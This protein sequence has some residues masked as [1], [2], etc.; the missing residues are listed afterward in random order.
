[1]KALTALN[2]LRPSDSCR[3]RTEGN[4]LLGIRD[5]FATCV[6]A[7]QALR[8][9]AWNLDLKRRDFHPRAML[10][11]ARS[12]HQAISKAQLFIMSIAR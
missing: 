7:K 1:M 12:A 3:N 5:R 2:R 6:A 10:R 8:T 11:P 9:P 4:A